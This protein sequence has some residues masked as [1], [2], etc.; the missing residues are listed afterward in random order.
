MIKLESKHV[1]QRCS[2]KG[3]YKLDS[4]IIRA[5]SANGKVAFVEPAVP[6]PNLPAKSRY[7]EVPAAEIILVANEKG[8]AA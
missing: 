6:T 8:I 4:Y 5:I 7:E 1:G 2:I 3:R